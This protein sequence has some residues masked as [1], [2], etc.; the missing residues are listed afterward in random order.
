VVDP[1]S[2]WTAVYEEPPLDRLERLA[3]DPVF[4]WLNREM[5]HRG[6]KIDWTCLGN[7]SRHWFARSAAERSVAV[8]EFLAAL[9]A[10]G[11]VDHGG[12]SASPFEIRIVRSELAS[13]IAALLSIPEHH[14]FVAADRSWIAAFTTEG[15]VD[16]AFL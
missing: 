7:S 6:S 5:P 2:Y 10:G 13:V 11:H 14:Y 12:D 8:D 4:D 16:L 3:G 15:D 1:N 9:P